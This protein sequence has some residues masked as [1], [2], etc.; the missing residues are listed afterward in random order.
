MS[1]SSSTRWFTLIRREMQEYKVSLFWTPVLL[2]AALAAIMLAGVGFANQFSNLGA[3]MLQA[4]LQDETEDGIQIRIDIGDNGAAQVITVEPEGELRHDYRIE[5]LPE[6]G[7]GQ[8][9][10]VGRLPG[11][12]D[13]QAWNF[14]R[15]WQFSAPSGRSS[16]D[17]AGDNQTG[18]ENLNPLLQGI[19]VLMLIVLVFVTL[20]YLLGCLYVDRKDRSIL[21]W[22]SMPVSAW[23]EV[24]AK[25][26]V[27]LLVAPAL[28]IAASIFAQLAMVLLAALLLWQ[29]E[30]D[31]V[32]LVFANIEPFELLF[33]QIA[34]WLLTALWVAPTYAWV[35]LASAGARRSPFLLAVTPVAGLV[36]LESI[37]FGSSHLGRA[38]LNHFPHYN[39]GGS[40]SAVGFYLFGP[41]WMGQDYLGLVLGLVC[42]AVLLC[43]VVWLRR[44]RWEL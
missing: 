18:V 28:F 13:D 3:V 38:M 37:L 42:A 9:E 12:A 39:E 33:N 27:A 17:S 4:V 26:G 6:D 43:G 22:K 31:A 19:H 29:Q 25:L 16:A 24:L 41:D 10:R 14:S 7:N 15:E 8:D 20:N 35:M 32:E 11:S 34:G 1:S 44:H 5:D 21:F 30:L 2:A 40:N 23:E 36:L